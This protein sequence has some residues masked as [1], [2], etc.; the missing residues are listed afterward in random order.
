MINTQQF[1]KVFN[2]CKS[3]D[4]NEWV[5]IMKELFPKYYINTPNRIAAFLAQ[6]GHESAN[7]TVF[8][9][10]LN[11]SSKALD[12]IFH[13]Y[14]KD[15]GLNSVLY[16]RQ[17]ELIANV[18]YANRMGNTETGD[19]WKYRGRGVI[20]LTG[21]NNYQMFSDATGID[22][23][24]NPELITENKKIAL[25]TALWFWENNNLNILADNCY[26]KKMTK[27]INGGYHGLEN[28]LDLFYHLL[29]ALTPALK[30]GSR[31]EY[32]KEIQIILN[33]YADGIFGNNTEKAVKSWQHSHKLVEDGI[34]G[35]KTYYL[36]KNSK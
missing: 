7:F 21:K 30:R 28:R 9:E 3:K 24:N 4:A 34:V 15:V 6:C 1:K 36:M 13:K 20:Q 23:V 27:K 22:V 18:I 17:P 8:S 32:V 31:G 35:P 12:S 16:H 11:Y 14:F 10:N 2:R 5:D 19:G 33:L 25:E 29:S 26:F